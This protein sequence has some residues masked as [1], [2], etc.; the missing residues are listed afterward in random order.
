ML[1]FTGKKRG[2]S[3]AAFLLALS[4]VFSVSAIAP[5][6]ASAAENDDK[7]VSA[8]A[9]SAENHEYFHG[10][11]ADGSYYSLLDEGVVTPVKMQE[12]GTCW[13]N[14]AATSMESCRLK[15]N[16]ES[17]E[18][19]PMALLDDVYLDPEHE[20][21]FLKKGV[22]V[23]EY[24]GWN[25]MVVESAANG[26]GDNGYVL[27]EAI[28]GTFE[29]H[30][31][32]TY[33]DMIRN[34]G[35]VAVSISDATAGAA[36]KLND[37]YCTYNA[38][39]ADPDHEAVLI[40]W[41]DNFP[42]E[43]FQKKASRDGAFLCQN[44]RGDKWGKGG[45]YW[46]SYD[47]P[48]DSATSYILT[49]NYC[50]VDH[51]DG[52]KENTIKTGDTTTV[53]NVFSSTGGYLAAV[54]TYTM[55]QGQKITVEVRDGRFGDL[56]ATVDAQFDYPG[57]HIVRL[58]EALDVKDYSIDV[59]YDGEAPV[60]GEDLEFSESLY[61][62]VGSEAGQSFVL[63]KDEWLDL[64]DK[65]TIAKL[66]IDFEPNNACVK[67]LFKAEPDKTKAEMIFIYV[68]EL[69]RELWNSFTENF[70]FG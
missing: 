6:T 30:D 59:T 56:L 12:G 25:W 11:G 36:Y 57:Y 26:V 44:S 70:I 58:P 53:G 21:F 31:I 47:T 22:N 61:Y 7:A 17:I 42:A 4:M 10:D 48:L 64:T 3:V 49:D 27:S 35:G 33:K 34:Y 18:I 14:G 60:E 43:Y 46:V 40:G 23:V 5:S 29:G 69:I 68:K 45:Y 65:T 52:G 32:D 54:G 16:G 2:T 63:I 28:D 62:D 20:G 51:Y 37:G 66:A 67:A 13:V 39:D 24:G 41:D 8:P 9:D 15:A 1:H 38:P 55:Y 50:R 19:D